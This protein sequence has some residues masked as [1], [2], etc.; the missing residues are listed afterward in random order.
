MSQ[1]KI[2]RKKWWEYLLN[3]QQIDLSKL[4]K[5]HVFQKKDA[6]NELNIFFLNKSKRIFYDKTLMYK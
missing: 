4:E 2:S 3:F 6:I 5:V 1:K